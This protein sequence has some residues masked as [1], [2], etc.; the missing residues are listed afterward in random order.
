MKMTM[1]M[2]DVVFDKQSK[3]LEKRITGLTLICIFKF[4]FHGWSWFQGWECKILV[5]STFAQGIINPIPFTLNHAY[6]AAFYDW[7]LRIVHLTFHC[8][9]QATQWTWYKRRRKHIMCT[10]VNFCMALMFLWCCWSSA[11]FI[12]SVLIVA[13]LAA[14]HKWKHRKTKVSSCLWFSI[15]IL[16]IPHIPRN[17]ITDTAKKNVWQAIIILL[18]VVNAWNFGQP[19]TERSPQNWSQLF[20]PKVQRLNANESL[21][22]M[23]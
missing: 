1:V 19:W 9:T 21:D 3:A 10:H 14:L 20:F 18:E 23:M 17:A 11:L 12:F 13:F 4:I 7:S 22:L 5:L 15:Q 8:W 16:Y 6:V 2:C